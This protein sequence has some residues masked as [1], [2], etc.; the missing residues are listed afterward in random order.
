MSDAPIKSCQTCTW[1]REYDNGAFCGR[2]TPKKPVEMGMVCKH[3]TPP[4][5]D[6]RTGEK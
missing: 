6:K 5:S 4:V 3:Y 1:L 2:D